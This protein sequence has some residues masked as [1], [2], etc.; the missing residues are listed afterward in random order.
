MWEEE[1]KEFLRLLENGCTTK[2]ISGE[3]KVPVKT[4]ARWRKKVIDGT[5]GQVRPGRGRP[6]K[7][8]NRDLRA[9]RREANKDSTKS[10]M[11]LVSRVGLAV[12][13]KTARRYIKQVRSLTRPKV[14]STTK[15]NQK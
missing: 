5:F 1:K 7:A 9:L 2:F 13:E 4:I 8:S 12:C 15:A 10:A 11:D 14:S 6:I 3:T